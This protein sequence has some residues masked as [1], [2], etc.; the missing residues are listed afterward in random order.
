MSP[1]GGFAELCSMDSESIK[2]ALA[3]LRRAGAE[4]E[5]SGMA[6]MAGAAA[7]V[8][9]AE[10]AGQGDAEDELEFPP[11]PPPDPLD[12]RLQ[13]CW[14]CGKKAPEVDRRAFTEF[15]RCTRC[16]QYEKNYPVACAQFC[17]YSCYLKNKQRSLK[18]HGE[19]LEWR[20]YMKAAKLW[21]AQGDKQQRE[22]YLR[23]A[24]NFLEVHLA[25]PQKEEEE[26]VVVGSGTLLMAGGDVFDGEYR[27]V[28]S[29]PCR[30]GVGT[31]IEHEGGWEATRAR[32]GISLQAF[33]SLATA[34]RSPLR[35]KRTSPLARA[36]SGRPP[37]RRRG[38]W[39]TA[40]QS[41]RSRQRRRSSGPQRLARTC[42][43]RTSFRSPF[44]LFLFFSA[45]HRDLGHA[46]GHPGRAGQRR[47]SVNGHIHVFLA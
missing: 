45:A 19:S 43:C 7:D 18:W 37:G 6:G 30:D 38:A 9:A 14:G 11:E 36:C 35:S 16:E 8:A 3:S 34:A 26:E 44:F 10:G 1:E 24:L 29:A 31:R 20:A 13:P 42:R 5:E 27:G 28:K 33:T 4:A 40:T 25:G 2:L 12:D 15:M 39:S 17:S 32:R 23:K 22:K 21:E 47:G 41:R 46:G